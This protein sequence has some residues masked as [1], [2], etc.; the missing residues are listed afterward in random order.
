MSYIRKPTALPPAMRAFWLCIAAMTLLSSVYTLA[1]TYIVKLPYPYGPPLFFADD[2]WFDFAIYH[3]RF[4]HFRTAS[5]W[6]K[7]EY[8]F[9]YPASLAVLYGLLYKIPHT[10]R[11]YLL[12]YAAV[13][14]ACALVFMRRL[15]ERGLAPGLALAFATSVL[16]V[17]YPLRTLFESGNTEGVVA[18]IAGAGLCFVLRDRC[19]LG[20][21]LIAIA[22]TMK[23][24]PFVL[25]A[26]LLSKRRYR[27]FAWGLIVAAGVTLAS[28]AIVG[29]SIA[30]AQRQID[31]GIHYVKYTFVFAT[32]PAAVTFNHSLFT[33]VKFGIVALHRQLYPF[34]IHTHADYLARAASERSLLDTTFNLY[35]AAVVLFGVI[36]YFGWMRRMPLLNQVLWLTGCG[37]LLP[38]LSADYTLLHLLLPF[39]LLCFYALDK[40]RTG[41][42]IPGLTACFLCFAPIFSFQTYL[43]YRYRFS[44]EFRTLGLIALLFVAMRYRF[45]ETTAES[46]S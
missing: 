4:Q 19:W 21:T 17:N 37:L 12:T 42:H 35:V 26:L 14:C 41:T 15:R 5:F 30:E 33:L 23:I 3:D 13:A 40:W 39:A 27:E 9:T 22:G 2:R 34:A 28:L 36:G 46:R 44:C 31:A 38:P 1:M 8:P 7:Y 45:A 18:I 43:T 11:F 24:F 29:P 20:A 25:L 6:D 10:L 32:R 16:L